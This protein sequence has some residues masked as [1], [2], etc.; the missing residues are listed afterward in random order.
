M[1]EVAKQVCK[2]GIRHFITGMARGCD[3]IF[4]EAMLDL[5]EKTGITVE[6]AI[7]YEKQAAGWREE[8]RERYRHL[9]ERC[10][11]ITY[12]GSEYTRNCNLRRNRYMVD[13]SS[14]LIAVYDGKT[15]GTKYTLE[16]ATR[17]ELEVVI[18][19]P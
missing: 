2:T 4:C 8:E 18:I 1:T 10:D 3:T 5:R 17:R 6:A 9:L 16:Y 19:T 15:G 12:V 14:V 7:P 11:H 13:N